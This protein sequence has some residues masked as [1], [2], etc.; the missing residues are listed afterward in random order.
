MRFISQFLDQGLSSGKKRGKFGR[1]HDKKKSKP[2]SDSADWR[3][4]QIESK[5]SESDIDLDE[6]ADTVQTVP[7]ST[8]T[9]NQPTVQQS[10]QQDTLK[11]IT[12]IEAIHFEAESRTATTT[13]TTTTTT[14][15]AR[16]PVKS[17]SPGQRD[18]KSLFVLSSS[19]A[20]AK[21]NVKKLNDCLKLFE[22]LYE[23]KP[24]LRESQNW[25]GKNLF[26]K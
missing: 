7:L 24:E 12:D 10:F 15:A 21:S 4:K 1:K 14:A 9:T 18:P 5:S 11:I 8:L 25:S 22:T 16:K 20:G 13:T 17:G 19:M 23:K 2:S 26:F 6:R 3:P